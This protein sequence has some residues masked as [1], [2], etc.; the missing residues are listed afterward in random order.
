MAFPNN[1]KI[2]GKI[3]RWLVG[4]IA[5]RVARDRSSRTEGGAFSI[6][7]SLKAPS[8]IL[9]VPDA[10]PGG[11]FLAAPHFYAIRRH[12]PDAHLTMLIR[13]DREYI[14]REIPFIQERVVYEEFILPFGGKVTEVVRQLEGNSFDIAFCFSTEESICPGYL[15]RKSGAHLRIG[16]Q[17]DDAT[18]YNIQVV[19]KDAD[20]YE[21]DRLALLPRIFGIPEVE[22]RISWSVSDDGT[23]RIQQRFLV[24]RK[25]EERFLA[26]DISTSF[27]SRP[28]LRQF[29]TIAKGMLAEE[30]VRLLL[31][32]D[33]ETR[34]DANAVA[35]HVR[36]TLGARIL[37]F[38]ADDLPRV[39]A[40]LDACDCLVSCNTDLFHLGVSARL[41]V[42]GILNDQERRRWAPPNATHV[43]TYAVSETKEWSADRFEN[44]LKRARE[45]QDLDQTA[46]PDD[47]VS[48]ETET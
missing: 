48:S 10:R 19:P 1:G 4:P 32:F 29:Q 34:K 35:D 15:C 3:W 42:I 38:Q 9:I 16:I 5:G 2:R 45:P 18:Y 11:I 41:P 22:E 37:P 33:Y 47:V 44:V 26:L 13:S 28:S 46:V 12:Y 36:E 40:L 30:D 20:A 7:E 27:G 17:R 8:R 24:G 21:T 43:Q 25:P 23:R 39:A 14:A 31:F 6:S